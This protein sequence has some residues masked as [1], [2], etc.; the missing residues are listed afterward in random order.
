MHDGELLYLKKSVVNFY[1]WNILYNSK[2]K[3]SVSVAAYIAISQSKLW[4]TWEKLVVRHH[5]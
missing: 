4:Y 5:G 2:K 3:L 1:I